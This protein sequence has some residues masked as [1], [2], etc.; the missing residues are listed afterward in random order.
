MMIMIIMEMMI[1]NMRMMMMAVM[2]MMMINKGK[3]PNISISGA[4]AK[5][6]VTQLVSDRATYNFKEKIQVDGMIVGEY[7]GDEVPSSQFGF[8][9]K[10][11]TRLPDYFF[12]TTVA[13]RDEWVSIL[14][15]TI[16]NFGARKSTLRCLYSS[17]I[18]M[19]TLS[20]HI[21]LF[22]HYRS[23]IIIYGLRLTPFTMK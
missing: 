22:T 1:I 10:Y 9:V 7:D 23:H 3:K 12:V 18:I 21:I 17:S 2:V 5:M 16:S 19:M 20:Y 11:K 15:Q 8:F 14:K 6:G 4:L 13:M